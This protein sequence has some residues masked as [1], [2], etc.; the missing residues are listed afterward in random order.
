MP[1]RARVDAFPMSREELEQKLRVA[2]ETVQKAA[3]RL[4]TTEQRLGELEQER[5]AVLGESEIARRALSQ[6]DATI[7]DLRDELTALELEEARQA[8]A[9]AVAA[10]DGVIEEAAAT[11]DAAVA[12]LEEVEV[13]RAAVEAARKRVLVLDPS[14]P[15]GR[16]G[17]HDE[18]DTL[19]EPWQ[20]M[21]A[22]VKDQLDEELETEVVDAAARSNAPYAINA[23]PEHLRAV[24]LER[25]RQLHRQALDRVQERRR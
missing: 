8:L 12:L 11:L 20:R 10:R 14:G 25:R 2:E 7:A 18:P 15:S 9:D 3:A 5:T 24:A 21:V 13:R 16:A 6:L 23:L 19:H 22:A 17:A 1:V 4:E